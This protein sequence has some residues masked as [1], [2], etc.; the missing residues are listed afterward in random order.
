MS[1]AE[2]QIDISTLSQG[3]RCISGV[4]QG[5]EMGQ[6]RLY[7]IIESHV[8]AG[9]LQVVID[10]RFPLAEAAQAP[11]YIESRQAF[12]RVLLIP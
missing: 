7:D 8:A 1:R 6:P 12:G 5:A 3:N 9:E 11:A 4:F 10:R 2:R